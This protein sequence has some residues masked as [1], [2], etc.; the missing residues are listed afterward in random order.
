MPG[1]GSREIGPIGAGSNGTDPSTARM[2]CS[3]A[4]H[5]VVHVLGSVPS[6]IRTAIRGGKERRPICG[7]AHS[8][9]FLKA[10]GVRGAD[11]VLDERD[12]E[13]IVDVRAG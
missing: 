11:S 2:M 1:V 10:Q 6:C 3:G 7:A 5:G 9:N 13:S 4:R 8:R 12:N